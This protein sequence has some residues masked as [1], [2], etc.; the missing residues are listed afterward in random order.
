M[1]SDPGEGFSDKHSS[2]FNSTSSQ[3]PLNDRQHRTFSPHSTTAEPAPA[4]DTTYFLLDIEDDQQENR[5]GSALS[6]EHRSDSSSSRSSRSSV[7]A[8]VVIDHGNSLPR[9]LDKHIANHVFRSDNEE[10]E[11]DYAY[12]YA[13]HDHGDQGITPERSPSH[14]SAEATH[15][16]E[17]DSYHLRSKDQKRA[18][19]E[20]ARSESYDADHENGKG[21][22][23]VYT[24]EDED[25]AEEV[26]TWDQ[27]RIR[28]QQELSGEG[29][30]HQ[31]R[32]KR[33]RH[34]RDVHHQRKMKRRLPKGINGDLHSHSWSRRE[35]VQNLRRPGLSSEE[36]LQYVS[37][38]K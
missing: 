30:D 4:E 9:R 26:P 15:A 38:L 32:A 21:V 11:S 25:L 20:G 18:T 28:E 35:S 2:S 1:A 34:A 19:R 14:H 22:M 24:E 29:H 8:Q 5:P 27:K 37:Y 7:S 33:K 31:P 6:A 3:T 17:E 16:G 13:H 10:S 12:S 36:A 23:T